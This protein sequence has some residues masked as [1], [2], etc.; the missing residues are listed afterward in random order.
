MVFFIYQDGTIE[1]ADSGRIFQGSN[2]ATTVYAVAP[3]EPPVGLQAVF[4]LPDGTTT[5]AY[6][7]EFTKGYKDLD[8]VNLW[9]LKLPRNVTLQEGE[10]GVSF[11][12]VLPDGNLTTFTAVFSVEYSGIPEPPGAT[13]SEFDEIYALLTQYYNLLSGTVQDHTADIDILQRQTTA[14]SNGIIALDQRVTKNESDIAAAKLDISGLKSTAGK[15]NTERKQ[16]NITESA[17][18]DEADTLY[19]FYATRWAG[20]VMQAELIPY[21]PDNALKAAYKEASVYYFN[22]LLAAPLTVNTKIK[23]YSDMVATDYTLTVLPFTVP[24]AR[25][26]ALRT[27]GRKV[28]NISVDFGKRWTAAGVQEAHNQYVS[29][30]YTATEDNVTDFAMI[31]FAVISNAPTG[32]YRTTLSDWAKAETLN[33]RLTADSVVSGLNSRAQIL[34]KTIQYDSDS[35]TK[36]DST[37]LKAIAPTE[38]KLFYE[39]DESIINSSVYL[40]PG[41]TY[42]IPVL[43]QSTGDYVTQSDFEAAIGEITTRL[44]QLTEV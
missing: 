28:F 40:S 9:S 18:I 43:N 10:V 34:T 27:V 25:V 42:P 11:N 37:E 4:T 44:A 21:Y 20:A 13:E 38:V 19:D 26:E 8:G 31:K 30:K 3:F 29:F 12:A 5:A 7:M 1:R 16:Y 6:V 2:N 22:V 36:S 17:W 33:R 24:S 32:K 35:E 39:A 14:N 15:V 23:I 41:E